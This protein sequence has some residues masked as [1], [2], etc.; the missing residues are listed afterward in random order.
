MDAIS[1]VLGVRSA[2]L[3]SSQLKDLIYRAGVKGNVVSDGHGD[4]M[5]NDEEAAMAR[6][7][8]VMAAYTDKK[9]KQWIYQRR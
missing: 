6:K 9:G 4:D 3:R 5:D 1:F 2:Q 8:W 7:A